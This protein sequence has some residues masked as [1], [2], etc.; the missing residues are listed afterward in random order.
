MAEQLEAGGPAILREDRAGDR[1]A[2]GRG[3]TWPRLAGDL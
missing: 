1:G 3:A 2:F